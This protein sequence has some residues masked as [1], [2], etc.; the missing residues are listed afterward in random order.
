MFNVSN[1]FKT[2]LLKLEHSVA[3]TLSMSVLIDASPPLTSLCTPAANKRQSGEEMRWRG[4]ATSPL[5]LQG[6]LYRSDGA[7]YRRL[8]AGGPHFNP[9]VIQESGLTRTH[10]SSNCGAAARATASSH[11]PTHAEG[12]GGRRRG[13]LPQYRTLDK[14]TFLEKSVSRIQELPVNPAAGG[15]RYDGAVDM[16]KVLNWLFAA[17][18]LLLSVQGEVFKGKATTCNLFGRSECTR[19]RPPGCRKSVCSRSVNWASPVYAAQ[20]WTRGETKRCQ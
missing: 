5:T 6:A 12:R 9:R 4:D 16:D 18:T 8:L 1:Y 3:V 13:R 7:H 19:V 14:Y 17:M 20:L 2:R 15:W 10:S 11:T